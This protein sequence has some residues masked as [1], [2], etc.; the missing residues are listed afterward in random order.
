MGCFADSAAYDLPYRIS[1]TLLPRVNIENCAAMC[2]RYGYKYAGL[3]Y[4]YA[5]T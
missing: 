5:I 1:A 2:A 3:Q 4:G